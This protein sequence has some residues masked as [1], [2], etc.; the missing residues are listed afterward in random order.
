MKSNIFIEVWKDVKGYEGLYQV[1]NLGKVKSFDRYVNY[2]NIKKRLVKGKL[3]IP[4]AVRGYSR[5]V[6]YKNQKREN[7]TIHRLV[8]E[9]FISNPDSLPE[10]DHIN[11]CRWDNAVWNLKWV[12]HKGQYEN[13]YTLQNQ[14]KSAIG[15]YQP[16]GND[17]RRSVTILQYTKDG[18]FVAEYIGINQASIA[19]GIPRGNII[20]VLKGRRNIAGGFIWKYA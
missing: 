12:T 9:T 10:V 1:S 15:K 16:K 3:L 19:T 6:L 11:T 4:V 7:K 17:N 20:A 13:P 14:S 8:A 5:V 18:Q 2:K